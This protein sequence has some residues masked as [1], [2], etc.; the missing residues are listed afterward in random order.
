M[1]I[2]RLLNQT[3]AP[4]LEQM[5]RF[6]EQRAKLLGENIVNASTPNYQQKDLSLAEFQ[7]QLS[8]Q[9]DRR[10]EASPG[11]VT[12]DPVTPEPQETSPNIMFHDRNN[13]SIESLMS[14]NASNAMLHNL[15]TE[16]LRKQFT[17]IQDALKERVT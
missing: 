6:T 16:L 7:Q 9:V 5:V 11:Q 15:M 2:D 14:D 8:E 10:R 4:L 1:F 17:S 3:N 13:R 12:I